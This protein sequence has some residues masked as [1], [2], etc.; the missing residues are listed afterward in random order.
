MYISD[1]LNSDLKLLTL[2]QFKVLQKHL[3]KART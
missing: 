2:D 3:E 1:I